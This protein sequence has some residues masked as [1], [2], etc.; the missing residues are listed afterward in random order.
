[1]LSHKVVFFPPIPALSD[2][3]ASFFNSFSSPGYAMQPM[4][5]FFSLQP[6]VCRLLDSFKYAACHFVPQ[7]PVQIRAM[8]VRDYSSNLYNAASPCLNSPWVSWEHELLILQSITPRV[9]SSS[10]SAARS[11]L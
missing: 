7:I 10:G 9:G 6:P 3:A 8:S 4:Q 5:R 2:A 1:M 11:Y